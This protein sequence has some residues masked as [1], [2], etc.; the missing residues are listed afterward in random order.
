MIKNGDFVELDYTGK[1]KDD[2]IV[3]DTTVEQIAK[4]HKIH[5]PKF[6][7]KPIV[8]CM[9]E[10]HVVKGLEDALIGKNP[11]I[12]TI[13]VKAEHAFGKKSTELLKLI[14]MKLFK[15][16]NVQPFVGLEVNIDESLGIVRSVSGGRVIVDFN[17]PLSSKDLVYDIE[18]KRI[19][20]DPLEKV[21][22]VLDMLGVPFETLDLDDVKEKA[23]IITRIKYPDEA[24]AE[25]SEHVKR[26]AGMK[27]VE[28]Q[29]QEKKKE[30]KPAAHPSHSQEKP[31]ETHEGGEKKPAKK[32]EQA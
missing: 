15:K 13:E 26:L 27:A 5:N 16:D 31:A 19:V 1:V 4:D 18:V 6:R 28:F 17:H 32:K 10:H 14:P 23:T 25:V 9:G 7:Y 20:T 3:F 8:I 24:V 29:V 21:R 11:G 2:K 22:A 12:Y 30:E